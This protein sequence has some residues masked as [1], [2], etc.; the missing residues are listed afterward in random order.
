VSLFTNACFKIVWKED[1]IQYEVLNLYNPF[2]G[3]VYLPVRMDSRCISVLKK[4]VSGFGI[5]PDAK[6]DLNP[7]TNLYQHC[8]NFMTVNL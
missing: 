3:D 1:E 8:Q 7:E 5:D 6:L 2:P 4:P